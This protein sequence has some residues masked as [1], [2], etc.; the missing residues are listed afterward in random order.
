[1][2]RQA[3]GGRVS[4]AGRPRHAAR[5]P[6]P[7][8]SFELCK[9]LGGRALVDA[10]PEVCGVGR[11]AG[12]RAQATGPASKVQ[13]QRWRRARCATAGTELAAW[14]I[15]ASSSGASSSME[16][17]AAA[18]A[19]PA[20]ERR[21]SGGTVGGRRTKVLAGAVR[22]PALVLLHPLSALLQRDRTE[23]MGSGSVCRGSAVA[24]GG[25]GGRP[26]ERCRL[27]GGGMCAP[28]GGPRNNAAVELVTLPLSP[29][30]HKRSCRL[31]IAGSHAAAAP[32]PPAPPRRRRLPW[33]P[34]PRAPGAQRAWAASL[35]RPGGSARPPLA[36]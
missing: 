27:A 25:R 29:L 33:G 6:P 10:V 9:Q 24:H 13:H 1:M 4:G 7:I 18:A 23:G 32:L 28:A 19:A 22:L 5:P 26:G 17:A 35:G 36:W 11:G 2:Q 3:T 20:A 14:P 12:G 21:G 16:Q 8:R 15:R 30:Q 34:A 31:A